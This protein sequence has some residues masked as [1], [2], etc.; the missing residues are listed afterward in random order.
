MR[1]L[2]FVG[3]W[4]C[5]CSFTPGR[6]ATSDGGDGLPSDALEADAVAGDAPTKPTFTRPLQVGT[7]TG[8]PHANFPLLVAFTATWLRHVGSGGAVANPNGYDIVFTADAAGSFPLSHEVEEYDATDGRLVAWVKVSSLA[9][10][11]TLYLHGGDTSVVTSQEDAP[12]VWTEGF[13]GV[14]HLSGLTDSLAT[15]PGTATGTTA[16]A[17]KIGSGRSFDGVDDQIEVGSATAI[18]DVFASGGTAEAWFLANS[19]GGN[20]RGRIFAKEAF[21][22]GTGING[23]TLHVYDSNPARSV[24]L[25]HSSSS[26]FG[27]WASPAS[28][29]TT[30]TWH[31]V[32]VTYN[33]S[34]AANVPTIYLDGAAVAPVTSATA[35]VM[36][37]D[38]AYALRLGNRGALDRAFDGLL[39]EARLSKVIRNA[40]WIATSYQ[41][42]NA[43]EAFVTV[44]AAR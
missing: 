34:S 27:T 35:G 39:D 4:L 19:F 33:R 31:H 23:W 43:P 25:M 21:T 41:N 38:G 5:A 2:V 11:T 20:A 29:V 12:G 17:G 30:G 24:R 7:V 37:A 10:G 13:A 6:T 14:W 3:S 42:Q 44:G 36:E 28:S 32:A 1:S 22:T 9:T 26:G 40:G 18:D 15:S 16:A 8:G